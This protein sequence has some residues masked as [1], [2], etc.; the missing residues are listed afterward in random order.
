MCFV[1]F[2][3]IIYLSIT[4]YKLFY[5][6]IYLYILLFFCYYRLIA[7]GQLEIVTG[8][9]VMNDEATAHY[10]AMLEQMVEGHQWLMQNLGM[11]GF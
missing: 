2:Q 10:Y 7:D 3:C 1:Y 8:G 11:W 9:W 4:V 6:Y 5:I